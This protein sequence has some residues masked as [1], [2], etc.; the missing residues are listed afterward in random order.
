[1]LTEVKS[2][3]NQFASVYSNNGTY[4]KQWFTNGNNVM[5]VSQNGFTGSRSSAVW[6]S[7]GTVSGTDTLL[8]YAY[9]SNVNIAGMIGND[10][11]FSVTSLTPYRTLLYKTNFTKS[12]TILVKSIGNTNLTWNYVDN[13]VLYLNGYVKKAQYFYAVLYSYAS[14]T[15][16]LITG[17]NYF[18]AKVINGNLYAYTNGRDLTRKNLATKVV[19]NF[20]FPD[21][22]EQDRPRHVDQ[23]IGIQ[24]NKLYLKCNLSLSANNIAN[25]R[26]YVGNMLDNKSTIEFT[27]MRTSTGAAIPLSNANFRC[28]FGEKIAYFL[29]M[30]GYLGPIT[31][32]ST[33]GTSAGT[34]PVQELMTG[35]AWAFAAS[36]SLYLC[37]DRVYYY[38][39]DYKIGSTMHAGR[40]LSSGDA[41]SGELKIIDINAG[42]N[43]YIQDLEKFQGKWLY[44]LDS[45]T[46]GKLYAINGCA[47]ASTTGIGEINQTENS[48]SI[49][50]NPNNG[51]FTIEMNKQPDHSTLEIYTLTGQKVYSQAIVSSKISLNLN[52][53]SG[54]YF[55]N[56]INAKGQGRANKVI[57]Q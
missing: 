28:E 12:G 21:T 23:I 10:L 41:T 45:F 36:S 20:Y 4:G 2:I 33:D 5:F 42:T 48:I 14:D 9:G 39:V 26:I 54:V 43:P 8:T 25:C 29:G 55:L 40:A 56:I 37:G 44:S 19:T 11:Y 15:T 27:E 22:K 52:L 6:M 18:P 7:N 16:R 47:S 1:L 13:G 49:Y 34:K 3:G 17:E 31:L 38:G 24:N 57:I 32:F 53:Q 30:N 35:A 46:S 51:L 50:P